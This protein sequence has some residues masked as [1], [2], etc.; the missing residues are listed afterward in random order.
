MTAFSAVLTE[1]GK[2][3]FTSC[4]STIMNRKYRETEENDHSADGV[5]GWK[6]Q[7]MCLFKLQVQFDENDDGKKK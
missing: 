3:A 4:L 6:R 1:S 7:A 5:D 2:V